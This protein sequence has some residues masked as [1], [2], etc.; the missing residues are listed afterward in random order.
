MICIV[1]QL[2]E[3]LVCRGINCAHELYLFTSLIAIGLV[4]AQRIHPNRKLCRRVTDPLKT[5]E[6]ILCDEERLTINSDTSFVL[7]ISPDIRDSFE[8]GLIIQ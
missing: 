6:K 5:P 4:D 1:A 8:R 3:Y 2:N 7:R